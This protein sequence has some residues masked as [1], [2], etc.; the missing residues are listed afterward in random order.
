M[1]EMD[2]ILLRNPILYF[3]VK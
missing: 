2:L 1:D 3:D